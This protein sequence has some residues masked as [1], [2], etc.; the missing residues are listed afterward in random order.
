MTRLRI[1]RVKHVWL[2]LPLVVCVYLLYTY[3]SKNYMYLHTI[4]YI[5]YTIRNIYNKFPHMF[6]HPQYI[7]MPPYICMPP[8]ISH[9]S[10]YLM[11]T[12]IPRFVCPPYTLLYV[13]MSHT[14][15]TSICFPS[16]YTPYVCTLPYVHMPHMPIYIH[17]PPS[18]YAPI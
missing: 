15:H 8:V 17:M 11:C 4:Q 14:P 6:V 2:V 3:V 16:P 1:S 18:S 9:T 7:Y 12:Y 10:V 13:Y 5:H